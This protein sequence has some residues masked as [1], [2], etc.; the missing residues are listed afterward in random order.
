MDEKQILEFFSDLETNEICAELIS[1]QM[2]ASSI[3]GDNFK[4]WK[5]SDRP[6]FYNDTSKLMIEMMAFDDHGYIDERG[7]TKNPAR[8][9]EAEMK[10]E[11]DPFLKYFNKDVKVMI[12][13]NTD[14]PTDEDHNYAFYL[15]N[16]ISTVEKHKTK[17]NAYKNEHPSYKLIFFIFD[18]SSG[19][20]IESDKNIDTRKH[21][22]IQGRPHFHFW[23][24]NFLEHIMGSDIDFVIWFSPYKHT[25]PIKA[26]CLGGGKDRLP[27]LPEAVVIDVK[28]NKSFIKNEITYDSNKM[29]PN[30]I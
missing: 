21:G 3:L 26:V 2:V 11:I 19:I 9:H 23:D 24:K 13:G 8:A 15:N 29:Y 27:V 20:Y 1:E 4:K 12:N 10:K 22:F 16:F 30:E 18:E 5:H 14:L 6:D 28:N 17:I 7:K 25:E